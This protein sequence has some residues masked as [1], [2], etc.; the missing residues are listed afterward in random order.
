MFL[1]PCKK[2]SCVPDDDPILGESVTLLCKQNLCPLNHS[3]HIIKGIYDI[4]RVTNIF[5]GTWASL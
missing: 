1:V 4:W 5:T 2:A 3:P